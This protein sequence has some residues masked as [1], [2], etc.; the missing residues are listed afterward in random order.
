MYNSLLTAADCLVPAESDRFDAMFE[1]ER[2]LR[3][4]PPCMTYYSKD[5]IVTITDGQ[6]QAEFNFEVF[7]SKSYGVKNNAIR[8]G[9]IA[10]KLNKLHIHVGWKVDVMISEETVLPEVT[11]QYTAS[12]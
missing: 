1:P 9:S 3:D 10:I 7:I 5:L 4:L 8:F 12:I 6:S 2:V 11:H